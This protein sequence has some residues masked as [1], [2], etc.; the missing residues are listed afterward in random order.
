MPSYI[1]FQDD[2]TYPGHKFRRMVGRQ[3]DL[4]QGFD[5][6]NSFKVK[7]SNDNPGKLE[8]S[9]GIAWILDSMGGVYFVE[10]ELEPLYADTVGTAGTVILRVLDLKAFDE[11]NALVL[12]CVPTGT[13]IP[14][15]SLK[16]AT[17]TGSGADAVLTDVRLSTPGQF[18]V[19]RSGP[20]NYG[21]PNTSTMGLGP[22]SPGT[23]YTD[24]NTGLRYVKTT[25]GT[26]FQDKGPKGDTGATGPQGVQ[27]VAGPQGPQGVPGTGTVSAVNTVAPDGTGNVTLTPASLGAYPATGGTLNGF[28]S[29]TQGLRA[30]ITPTNVNALIT[31][32]PANTTSRVAIM[33]V[34]GVDKFSLATNGDLTLGGAIISPSQA[35]VKDV[36]A[37]PANV[38]ASVQFYSKNGLPYIKQGD[39]TVFQVG[40]TPTSNTP[41]PLGVF[42]PTGWGTNWKAKRNAAATGGKARMVVVGGSSSQGYYATNLHS[43]GWVGNVRAALQGQYGNG[44][45]GIFPVSRSPR[46]ID[47]AQDAAALSVWQANGSAVTATGTWDLGGTRTGPGATQIYTTTAGATL[48]FKVTGTTVKI[49]TVMGSGRAAFTYAIDGAAAVNVPN[50]ATATPVAVTTVT[51][52]T[53]AQHTVVLKHND[54]GGGSNYL[55]VIGVSGENASGVVVDNCAKAGAPSETFASNYDW[56]GGASYPA[57]LVVF[58]AGPNDVTGAVTANQWETN[59]M[60][61]I[62]AAR[63]ANPLVDVMLVL[64]H[65]GVHT[66]DPTLYAGYAAKARTINQTQNVALVDLW[67]SGLRYWDYWKAQ[68]FWGDAAV[69]GAEG[70]NSVHPGDKGYANIASIIA[71]VILG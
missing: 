3:Q 67:S 9:I 12:E 58:T 56:N 33:R 36:A 54:V 52:L 16:L 49:Y 48:T 31:D 20:S 24:L 44:G 8:A 22:F 40:A 38:A 37:D 46:Y 4:A 57:D 63:A 45:S 62:N 7:V 2:S 10:Q 29:T 42:V 25:G 32:M 21:A 23:Q 41:Q 19:S 70:S 17:Y 55:T 43:G 51:G 1:N 13:T 5:D 50:S 11:K 64:P 34:G 66:N 30:A 6:P 18:I 14:V 69:P 39:G 26:W 59:V 71:P 53:N 15:R 47:G 35:V 65:F 61:Y 60:T 28:I 27:G 68:G